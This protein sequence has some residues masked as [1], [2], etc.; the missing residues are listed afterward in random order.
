[1]W[2]LLLLVLSI[3]FIVLATTKLQLHPFLA[4]RR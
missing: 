1:M 4:H 3:V 2:L